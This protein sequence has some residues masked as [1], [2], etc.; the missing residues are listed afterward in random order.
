M[1]MAISPIVKEST[2]RGKGK[3]VLDAATRI[4]T[5]L[6]PIHAHDAAK[7]VTIAA[8]VS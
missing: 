5:G 2:T 8:I 4:P 6:P 1:K 7:P 3:F